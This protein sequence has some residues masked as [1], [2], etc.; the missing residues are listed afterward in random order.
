LAG[1]WLLRLWRPIRVRPQLKLEHVKH[2]LFI[3]FP[4]FFVGEMFNW[5]RLLEGT[6]VFLDLG[7]FG[8]GLYQMMLVVDAS[9]DL[10]PAAVGQV[11]YPRMAEHYGRHHDVWALVQMSHKPTLACAA[12][13][14][15]L[16]VL[17]W[18]LADPMTHWIAPKYV[19]AI[20]AMKWG[21][22]ASYVFS[23]SMVITI[24]NVVRR[25]EIYGIIIGISIGVYFV[26]LSYLVRNGA[27]LVAFAQAM[28]V[29]R[30]V[31]VALG[32]LGVLFVLWGA[33]AKS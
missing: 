27:T 22:V 7:K 13:M 5:W 8:M 26:T 12:G 25:Q 6:L 28:I 19:G 32:Y 2:L 20:E 16:I 23:F 14:L 33:K 29:A 4:I 17:G 1:F 3:G 21:L 11:I 24:F 30:V 18:F 10:L 9:A 15:P 31:F